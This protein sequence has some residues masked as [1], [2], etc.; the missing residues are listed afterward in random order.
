VGTDERLRSVAVTHGRLDYPGADIHLRLRSREEF[1]RLNACKKEPWTVRWIERHLERGDV[2]YDVGANVGAYTLVAAVAVPGLRVVAFEPGAANFAALCENVD[3]NGVG[4]RV[5]AVPLAL[6]RRPGVA[7]LGRDTSVPGA[8]ARLVGDAA[9]AG[10]HVVLV[11][12]LDDLAQRFGLPAPDHLKLDVDGAELDV[13]AGGGRVLEGLRSA[14][15][16]LDRERDP[17]VVELLASAGLDLVER[18]G[19]AD[20]A[21]WLPTYALFVRPR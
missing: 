14:M 1:H 7:A 3:L 6:G 9:P 13:L 10:T 2:L 20:R 19:G 5:M 16:E 12:R 15:V 11:D 18:A 8:S 21:H 4:E 17:E